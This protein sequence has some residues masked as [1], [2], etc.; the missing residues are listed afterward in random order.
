[1][2]KIPIV[3]NVSLRPNAP[4]S[5]KASY[6]SCRP[7]PASYMSEYSVLGLVVD[8]FDKAMEVLRGMDLDMTEEAFGAEITVTD[9]IPLSEIVE[10]LLESGVSTAIGDV[11]DSIYQG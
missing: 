11:I 9:R 6:S 2:K 1:M 10:R 7:L 8:H 5:E 4:R 3:P